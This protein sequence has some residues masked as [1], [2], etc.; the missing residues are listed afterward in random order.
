MY[1]LES[2]QWQNTECRGSHYF[3]FHIIFM[4]PLGHKKYLTV[5]FIKQLAPHDLV[6]HYV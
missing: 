1:P 6:R 5:P 4:A 3:S 2:S